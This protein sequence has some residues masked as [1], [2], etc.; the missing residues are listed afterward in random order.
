MTNEEAFFDRRAA[1]AAVLVCPAG[2]GLALFVEACVVPFFLMISGMNI[3]APSMLGPAILVIVVMVLI[4]AISVCV[5]LPLVANYSFLRP[6]RFAEIV[7][8]VFAV[9][10]AFSFVMTIGL[11]GMGADPWRVLIGTYVL[12]VF[13]P[14]SAAIMYHVT[15]HWLARR[16]PDE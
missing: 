1:I 16:H 6:L 7:V 14:T 11:W 12:F 10:S 5:L 2:A 3:E 8:P 4:V 13:P 9:S 15:Y